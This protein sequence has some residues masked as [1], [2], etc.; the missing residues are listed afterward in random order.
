MSNYLEIPQWQNSFHY[1]SFFDN[2]ETSV[3]PH[4]HR[5]IELILAIRGE[6][7]IGV[8]EEIITL[9]KDE[10]LF[11]ASGEPHYFLVSPGSERLVFQFDFSVFDGDLLNLSMTEMSDFFSRAKR[12]SSQW[13]QDVTNQMYQIL[14]QLHQAHLKEDKLTTIGLLHLLLATVEK[15]VPPISEKSQNNGY[16]GG[17]YKKIIR[18]LNQV[19]DYV[20]IHYME[21]ITLKDIS[22]EV[23]FNEQYFSRFFK[24][25]TG[26]TFIQFLN[27]YRIM[28]ASFYLTETDDDMGEVAEKSG[29]MT[30]KN[31]Q[32]TFKK[33]MGISPSQYKKKLKSKKST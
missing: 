10:I 11:F 24:E 14:N 13:P 5:E 23:G 28:K 31:F 29:F 25:N 8:G 12:V 15:K 30:T 19:Y 18:I 4:W 26:A 17:N 20:E 2:G 7:K 3:F 27:H 22:D 1:R 9:K 16:S 33:M 32:T 6:T 21:K